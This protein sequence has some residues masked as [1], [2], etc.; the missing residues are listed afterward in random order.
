[1]IGIAPSAIK[2][3]RT[4]SVTPPAMN[5]SGVVQAP[6]PNGRP[7]SAAQSE[8]AQSAASIAVTG[9]KSEGAFFFGFCE[10]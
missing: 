6:S 7:L 2:L 10:R 1:M 5:G 4:P 8:G 3:E 9:A